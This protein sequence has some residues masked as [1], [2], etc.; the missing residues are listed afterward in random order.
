MGNKLS[1]YFYLMILLAFYSYPIIRSIY[2]FR[3]GRY[4][5]AFKKEKKSM[6]AT[7]LAFILTLLYFWVLDFSNLPKS[8]FFIITEV[9]V[10]CYIFLI[11]I[12]NYLS[13]K[14]LKEKKIIY[15]T[16]VLDIIF[17][18]LGLFVVYF[19]LHSSKG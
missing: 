12:L 2:L 3:T 10:I 15:H 9:F 19:Y 5:S 7:F 4:T 18:I 11:T 8:I 17:I 6:K 16:V 13:Y 1:S 14:K